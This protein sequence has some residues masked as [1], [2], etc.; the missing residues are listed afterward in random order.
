MTVFAT[1]GYGFGD[2]DAL[3]AKHLYWLTVPIMSAVGARS[4]SYPFSL[5]I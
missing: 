2:M 1:F 4:N 5:L 3:T